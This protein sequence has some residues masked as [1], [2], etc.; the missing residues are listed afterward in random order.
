MLDSA[1]SSLFDWPLRLFQRASRSVPAYAA[2]LQSRGFD[3][4]AVSEPADFSRVPVTSKDDYLRAY[5]L[6]DLLWSG[7]FSGV[8]VLAASSGSSGT[9]FYWPQNDLSRQEAMRLNEPLWETFDC[10]SRSTLCIITF[11]MGTHVAA[12]YELGAIT[13]LT[14][15]G[16]RLT[17]ICPG[18]DV[19][20]SVTI[21]RDLASGF[22]QTVIM[23][24]PPIV[25][26][27][28]E[29]AADVALDTLNLRLVFSGATPNT[30][31]TWSTEQRTS[32][33]PSRARSV[34]T[35]QP[36]PVSSASNHR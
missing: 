14:Q 31:V 4:R 34:S 22:Q 26:D 11:A 2:F 35:A 5:P 1:H 32:P 21:L 23:G 9:P 20:E 33:T 7:D 36:T 13:G 29:A 18:I 8:G 15:R 30:G 25:K 6:S 24:Y 28:I 19:D 10:R 12:T 17:A 3:A 27:V 16:Y